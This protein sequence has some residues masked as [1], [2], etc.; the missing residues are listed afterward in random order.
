MGRQDPT[1]HWNDAFARPLGVLARRAAHVEGEQPGEVRAAFGEP[2]RLRGSAKI[3]SSTSSR[4]QPNK[5]WF[6]R[7]CNFDQKP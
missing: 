5:V 3:I 6:E 7:R 2:D 4:E 1:A